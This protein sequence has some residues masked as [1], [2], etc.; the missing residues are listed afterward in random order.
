VTATAETKRRDE[1]VERLSGAAPGDEIERMMYGWSVTHCLPA[2][3]V[4][5]PGEPTG[6]VLREPVVRDLADRAGFASVEVLPIENDFFR[7][8]RLRPT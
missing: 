6:T 7:F 3:M 4:D 8:Y 2:A 5:Q 1:L